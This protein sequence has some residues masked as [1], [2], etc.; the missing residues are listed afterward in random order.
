MSMVKNQIYVSGVSPQTYFIFR[1]LSKA[2]VD[3]ILIT[4]EKKYTY[5]SNLGERKFISDY[6]EYI[7]YLTYLDNSHLIYICSGKDI[8]SLHE[9]DNDYFKKANVIPND[10]YGLR[11]FLDK[12]NTYDLCEKLDLPILDTWLLDDEIPEMVYSQKLIAK[13]R[14]ENTTGILKEFKT[15]IFYSCQEINQFKSRVPIELHKKI[16][17]QRYIESGKGSNISFLGFYLHGKLRAGMLAQQLEQY[18]QGITSYL[19]EYEG[20]LADKLMS[21]AIKLIET[22]KYNGFCEV[23]FKLDNSLE[24]FYILEVNPRPCGWSSALLAKYSNLEEIIENPQEDPIILKTNI[25]WVNI[26]R[27]LRGRFALGYVPFVKG[28]LSIPFIKSYDLFNK[29]DLKP[30]LSQLFIWYKS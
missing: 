26:I 11:Y 2:D 15:F 22:T 18:P 25:T 10:I 28:L 17:L 7:S 16:I 12:I 14:V 21:A 23:E 6:G 20:P 8:Q 27:F 13:W 1:M 3:L 4:N 5:Y 24:N 19:K 9:K 29:K 30:F